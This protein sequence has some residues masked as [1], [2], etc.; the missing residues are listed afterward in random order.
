MSYA[1]EIDI[2]RQNGERVTR[3][4]TYRGQLASVCTACG[5]GS[6]KARLVRHRK[7]CPN[8]RRAR[9]IRF[10]W[11]VTRDGLE[12]HLTVNSEID[13]Y[14]PLYVEAWDSLDNYFTLTREEEQKVY[15]QACQEVFQMSV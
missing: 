5:H 15:E 3:I 11:T 9:F 12:I 14:K 10:P 7:G 6:R 8:R 13:G 1:S 4:R 2:A